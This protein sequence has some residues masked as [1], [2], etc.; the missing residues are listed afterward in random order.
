M[1]GNLLADKIVHGNLNVYLRNL[2]IAWEV[3]EIDD[4]VLAVLGIDD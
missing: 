3:I 2:F 1:D 4:V